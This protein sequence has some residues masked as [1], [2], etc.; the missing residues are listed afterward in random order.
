MVRKLQGMTALISVA[1]LC[2]WL[3]GSTFEAYHFNAGRSGQL[4]SALNS[5]SSLFS[6][7]DS[8]NQI[9]VETEQFPWHGD[10]SEFERWN[11]SRWNP[12]MVGKMG[13]GNNVLKPEYALEICP[14]KPCFHKKAV[15]HQCEVSTEVNY[16]ADISTDHF[17]RDPFI[18]KLYVL[19]NVPVGAMSDK[20]CSRFIYDSLLTVKA[21]IFLQ[22]LGEVSDCRASFSQAWCRFVL[23]VKENL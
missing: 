11:A 14:A 1:I 5:L 23:S 6:L 17:A 16:L 10:S 2:G 4:I 13:C 9:F 21:S 8:V 22:D 19:C 15:R 18:L 3:Q 20:T 12:G 7:W